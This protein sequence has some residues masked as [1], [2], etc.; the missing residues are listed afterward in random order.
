[1]I[2]DTLH[3]TH[4][5]RPG[6]VKWKDVAAFD[7]RL[8]ALGCK[9]LFL[10]AS[11]AT[12]WER[13]IVPRMSDEFIQQ[14]AQKF[15]RTYQEIHQYFVSEQERLAGL[16]SQSVMLKLRLNVDAAS[17]SAIDAGYKFWTDD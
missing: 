14:Y 15:G 16:F 17:G 10:E 8:A 7:E 3:L 2:L 6:V 5:V 9:L 12:I 1:V 13:G 11:P 4:C